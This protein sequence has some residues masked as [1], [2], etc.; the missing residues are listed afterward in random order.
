MEDLFYPLTR[1][2]LIELSY[3]FALKGAD[4]RDDVTVPLDQSCR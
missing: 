2:S 3:V 4:G 1:N